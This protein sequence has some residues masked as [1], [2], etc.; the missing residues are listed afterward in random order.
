MAS[1]DVNREVSVCGTRRGSDASQGLVSPMAARSGDEGGGWRHH[2]PATPETK[3]PP[4]MKTKHVTNPPF[5]ATGLLAMLLAGLLPNSVQAQL[6]Y[7]AN[8]GA[9]TIT[10]YSGDG[11]LAIPAAINGLPVTGIATNAFYG[12]DS[13][14]SVT[15]PASVTNI[16]EGAFAACVFLTAIDVDTNNPAFSSVDGVLFDKSRATLIQFPTDDR[17]TSYTVPGTVTSIG[18]DALANSPHQH[19][20]PSPTASSVLG[21]RRS[22]TAPAWSAWRSRTPS[23]ISGRMLSL[24]A[25]PW[26]A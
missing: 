3:K 9:I 22:A 6:A 4:K 12:S 25:I 1:M 10:G 17:S 8:N 14:T 24:A 11:P 2:G 23:P 16:G 26:R 18:T 20:S 15:I 5:L 21:P 19:P 13:L 7:T